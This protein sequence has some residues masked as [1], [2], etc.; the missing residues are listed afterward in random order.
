[1]SSSPT[2]LILISIGAGLLPFLMVMLTSFVKIAVV[3]S[4]VRSAIGTPQ[5][6]PNSVVTGLS[7]VLSLVVMAP[8]LSE[9]GQRLEAEEPALVSG[10][11]GQ[12]IQAIGI[13][14]EP[15]EAF[16]RRHTRPEHLRAFAS[17]EPDG[18]QQTSW[19]ALVPAFL[20]GQL[21]DAF[22]MGFA[23][24]LPFL[25]L[26]MLVSSVLLSLGMHMLSPATISLPLKLL[27]FAAADGW[28]L[29]AQSLL[30]QYL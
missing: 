13:A 6:P 21:N 25:V 7:L 15:V 9:V 10:A 8:V 30:G 5:I 18:G 1:M 28:T 20:V 2:T 22:R 4:I 12:M 24:F 16:L 26:D 3:L 19:R 23:I 27:L 17:F 14:F 11:P 29:I